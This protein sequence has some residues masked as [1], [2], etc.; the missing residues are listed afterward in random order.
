MNIEK[1]MK[2]LERLKAVH[3]VVGKDEG[4]QVHRRLSRFDYKIRTSI[5]VFGMS[6]NEKLLEVD[7]ESLK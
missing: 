5:N 4:I 2:T 7:S 1:A 3:I 6:K